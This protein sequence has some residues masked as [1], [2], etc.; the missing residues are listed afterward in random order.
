MLKAI[1]ENEARAVQ[2]R[3]LIGETPESFL[4][5]AMIALCGVG[6]AW[7]TLAEQRRTA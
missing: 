6:S 4:G 3:F 1:R 7:I 2:H 5:M